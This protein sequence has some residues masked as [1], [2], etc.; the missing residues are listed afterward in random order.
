MVDALIN[1]ILEFLQSVFVIPQIVV[2]LIAV[3]PIVEARL[4][5]PIA[6]EYG[7]P[8]FESWGLAF[9]GSTVI[10]PL[11]LLILIPF[12]KWLANTRLFKKIGSALMEK[13]EKKSQSV[14]GAGENAQDEPS[15]KKLE[16]KK[17]IGVFIFVAIPLPL[18][19]VWTGCAVASILNLK[20]PKALLAVSL[21]NLVASGIITLLCVFFAPY[22]DYIILALGIIAII[23]VIVLIIKII[24]HKPE[25]H[26]EDNQQ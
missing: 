18:T 13:F 4:A 23:V 2:T 12:I 9:V 16:W 14:Q 19:G 24:L 3:L 20:Y 26:T 25:K 1:A 6:M 22:T 5:L 11:L 21:G 15:R 8:W 17:A 7:L 10:A